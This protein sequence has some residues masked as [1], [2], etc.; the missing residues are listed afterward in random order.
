MGING[1]FWGAAPTSRLDLRPFW[2]RLGFVLVVAAAC[3]VSCCFRFGFCRREAAAVT[4][5]TATRNQK[6]GCKEQNEIKTK[7]KPAEQSSRETG[8][9]PNW[10]TWVHK[11]QWR[12]VLHLNIRLVDSAQTPSEIAEPNP[13]AAQVG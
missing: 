3:L 8:A 6:R 7:Q 9:V 12:A 13:R 1:P 5:T 4:E 10:P 2:F 11:R